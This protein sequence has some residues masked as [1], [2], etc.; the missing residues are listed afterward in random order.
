MVR[1]LTGTIGF[2]FFL[3]LG[4]LLVA[5]GVLVLALGFGELQTAQRV[6]QLWRLP[7]AAVTSGEVMVDGEVRGTETLRAPREPMDVVY[8][9]HLIEREE[10]DS[11]GRT[12]WRTDSRT[13]EHVPFEVADESGTVRVQPGGDVE[14]TGERVHRE[15]EGRFR[16]TVTVIRPGDP[17]VVMGYAATRNGEAAIFFDEPGAYVPAITNQGLSS[18]Q[19]S[20]MNRSVFVTSLGL[21]LLMIG[22]LL[23]LRAFR[24]HNVSLSLFLLTAVAAVA[25]LSMGLRASNGIVEERVDLVERTAATTQESFDAVASE[26]GVSPAP[27]WSD[28]GA[29]EA[30]SAADEEALTRLGYLQA[31]S[32]SLQ[33]N[34][35]RELNQFPEVLFYRFLGGRNILGTL[36]VDESY[37]IEQPE[38][39]GARFGFI[40][41]AIFLVLGL[42]TALIARHGFRRVRLKRLVEHMPPS[43]IKGVTYGLNE[44]QARIEPLARTLTSPLS[45]Q[46]CVY[47]KHQIQTKR[48]KNTHTEVHTQGVIFAARDEDGTIEVHP[49]GAE[50]H[51]RHSTRRRMGNR[52]ETEWVVVPGDELYLLGEARIHPEAPDRLRICQGD[53]DDDRTGFV[54]S[55]LSERDLLFK[56]GRQ[57]IIALGLSVC[58]MAV[59]GFGL[60]MM[61]G[62]VGTLDYFLATALSCVYLVFC[63]VV[64]LFND[65]VFLRQRVLRAWANIDVALKKR[66]D[67]ITAL[68]P[69]VQ[70]I[71]EHERGLFETVANLR[72][73]APKA[74][75]LKAEE[76]GAVMELGDASARQMIALREAYPQ[77]QSDEHFQKLMKSLTDVENEIALMRQ[78]YNDAVDRY[79][80]RIAKVPEVIVAK[81]AAMKEEPLLTETV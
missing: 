23:V 34:T 55:N 81:L 8:F 37:L 59:T 48:G 74:G 78:G 80:T 22:V 36:D 31:A 42:V 30:L 49:D 6:T 13:T 71:A 9:D 18:L 51:S 20:R 2:L 70:A 16:H 47:Y 58:G 45:N 14:F 56:M 63:F 33:N 32:A 41:V 60:F 40:P 57:G 5:G 21:L 75:G 69:V 66:F 64:L 68:V 35:H 73:A 27:R 39:G 26:V 77:L 17:I 43:P 24:V 53:K 72:S 67:L 54:I 61:V 25:M 79:N 19:A 52:T 65:L 11:E 46:A 3:G 62:S 10:R 4:V 38:T 50:V 44:I 28:S 15:V 29:L 1:V 7:A 12:T 76:A